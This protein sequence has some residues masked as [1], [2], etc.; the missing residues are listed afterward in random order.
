MIIWI[1]LSGSNNLD[2]FFFSRN[3]SRFLLQQ[4]RNFSFE[5]KNVAKT[6]YFHKKRHFAA[7]FKENKT[8][9]VKKICGFVDSEFV[10]I[11]HEQV[12]CLLWLFQDWSC[13]PNQIRL[14]EIW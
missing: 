10:K 2:Q 14:P 6:V 13:Q 5:I 1:K 9:F 12:T 8:F 11:C 3:F 7:P 4:G